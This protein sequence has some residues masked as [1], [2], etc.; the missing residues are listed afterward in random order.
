MVGA[1][2]AGAPEVE[3]LLEMLLAH[4][5]GLKRGCILL[6]SNLIILKTKACHLHDMVISSPFFT[7]LVMCTECVNNLGSITYCA[8]RTPNT[9]SHTF[10]MKKKIR[11]TYFGEHA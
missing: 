10:S 6:T 9:I 4:V 8:L 3:S 7:G 5:R 11:V 1:A 2:G